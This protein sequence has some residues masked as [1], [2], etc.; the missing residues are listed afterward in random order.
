MKNTRL[1]QLHY[2][3]HSE[4]NL[5]QPRLHVVSTGAS[6]LGRALV[7]CKRIIIIFTNSSLLFEISIAYSPN[8]EG[9]KIFI[10]IKRF[11]YF[12]YHKEKMTV[13]PRPS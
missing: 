9:T 7:K 13:T 2:I 8:G 4:L 11:G 3:I 1:F 10:F 12:T 6:Q 5:L